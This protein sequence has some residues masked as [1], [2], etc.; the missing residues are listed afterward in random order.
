MK[1][2]VTVVICTFNRYDLL[3]KAIASTELQDFPD[4]GYELIIVDNSDDLAGRERFLD[5]LEI[6][7]NHRYLSEARPG[8]SRAR[9]LGVSAASGEIVAFMDDDAKAEPDWLA[10]IA[11]TF[12]HHERAGIAGGP[13]RPIWTTPRPAWLHP[14]LESYLT[15]LDRGAATRILK[16]EEWL[17]G[18]NI[19]FRR[20]AL[21]QAG[22]FPEHLG[23]IGRLL[24]SNEEL[25]VS[26]KIRELGY[27]AV[28]NPKIVVHHRIHAERTSQAWLRRRVFWQAISDL[29]AEPAAAAPVPAD[30]DADIHRVLDFF[31]QLEPKNRGV[32]GLFV[33]LDDPQLFEE[34]TESVGALVRF[35][36][37]DAGD[38]R[39]ILA[40]AA[41]DR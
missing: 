10:H 12:T 9:N 18:T 39:R 23:R 41:D 19:A 15:I 21:K 33:D 11:D 28:Y 14:R 29:F 6:T 27:D 3:A 22:L 35:L 16:P 13:V 32:M 26:K 38:W 8:L 30:P 5:G 20:E 36:A 24:L 4:D 37:G 1:P 25:S 34:Q 7:C 17:A 40:T 31:D 2:Q